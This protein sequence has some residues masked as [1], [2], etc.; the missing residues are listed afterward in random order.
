[1]RNEQVSYETA[2][3]LWDAGYPQPEKKLMQMWYGVGKNNRGASEVKGLYIFEYS[4]PSFSPFDFVYVPT[5]T[6]LL[7]HLGPGYQIRALG[8]G[9][10]EC[11]M[12]GKPKS[13]I[14]NNPCE[15]LA[16]WIVEN[17]KQD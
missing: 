10:F 11:S 15:V 3:A 5:L 14:T 13:I 9:E 12:D 17:A 16:G 4:W 7:D 8:L 6:D 1:M 2:K